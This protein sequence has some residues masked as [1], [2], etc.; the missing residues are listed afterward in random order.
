MHSAPGIVY[1][2]GRFSW[3]WVC[4][5]PIGCV[6]AAVNAVLYAQSSLAASHASFSA[7]V[8][9]ILLI[10]SLRERRDSFPWAQLRWDGEYWFVMSDLREAAPQPL[11]RVE[12]VLDLQQALLLRLDGADSDVSVHLQQWVWLYKGFAPEQWHGLRCAV[13]SRQPSDRYA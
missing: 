10:T 11:A 8:L 6:A 9:L 4:G 5:L 2:L 7:A 3:F 13:Y 1:P 12:V